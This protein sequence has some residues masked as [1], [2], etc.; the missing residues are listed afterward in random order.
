MLSSVGQLQIEFAYQ[1]NHRITR[2]HVPLTQQRYI[3]CLFLY[4]YQSNDQYT[5]R[6]R[7]LPYWR[8]CHLQRFMG[9][10]TVLFYH[11]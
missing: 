2:Y 7:R 3:L 1:L 10:G 8:Q 5:A 6:T 4:R 9:K 11:N